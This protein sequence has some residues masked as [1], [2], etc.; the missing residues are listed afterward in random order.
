MGQFVSSALFELSER[1][2]SLPSSL[3]TNTCSRDHCYTVPFHPINLHYHT[4]SRAG[5]N[6]A[7]GKFTICTV[8]PWYAIRA[9]MTLFYLTRLCFKQSLLQILLPFL[10]RY[11][12]FVHSTWSLWTTI[13]AALRRGEWY[14]RCVSGSPLYLTLT[15]ILPQPGFKESCMVCWLHASFLICEPRLQT[16]MKNVVLI[17]Y[18]PYTNPLQVP[19][20]RLHRRWYRWLFYM[21]EPRYDHA[22]R[23]IMMSPICWCALW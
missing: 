4:H 23:C 8:A 14:T 19:V 17:S 1:F 3:L 13:V 18:S 15:D 20:C 16:R 12:F 7:E 11:V 10:Y 6:L 5:V 21:I 2:G 9:L 22:S